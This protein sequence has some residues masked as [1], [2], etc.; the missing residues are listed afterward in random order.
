MLAVIKNYSKHL[1][2]K[3]NFLDIIHFELNISSCFLKASKK[4][5]EF[6]ILKNPTLLCR[7]HN[8]K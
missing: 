8:V 5:V 7:C 1:N 2:L 3:L 4:S 6:W